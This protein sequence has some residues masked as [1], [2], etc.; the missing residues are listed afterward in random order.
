MYLCFILVFVKCTKTNTCKNTKEIKPE[1]LNL[2]DY[3]AQ[4]RRL[5]FGMWCAKGG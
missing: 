2:R 1:I 5:K 4:I 3:F